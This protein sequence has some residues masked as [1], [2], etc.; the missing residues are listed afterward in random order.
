MRNVFVDIAA[1]RME[2]YNEKSSIT[3]SGVQSSE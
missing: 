3:Q 2:R 1:E